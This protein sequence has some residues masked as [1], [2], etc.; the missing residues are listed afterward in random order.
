MLNR[1][2]VAHLELLPPRGAFVLALPMKIEGGT[3]GPCRILAILP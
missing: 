1:P 2:Y 3:G